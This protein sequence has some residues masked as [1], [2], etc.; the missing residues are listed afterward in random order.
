MGNYIN[1]HYDYAFLFGALM[2]IISAF[3]TFT[4]KD[5]EE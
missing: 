1:N 3:I 2:L 4:V 5:K